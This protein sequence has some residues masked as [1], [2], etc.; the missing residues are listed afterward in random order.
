MYL[1]F[2]C[3]TMTNLSDLILEQDDED[4]KNL[5]ISIQSDSLAE[6][7]QSRMN[8]IYMDFYFYSLDL[9]IR[10][11]SITS[12]RIRR[13]SKTSFFNDRNNEY[14]FDDEHFVELLKRLKQQSFV[15]T[16]EDESHLF[17]ALLRKLRSFSIGI[18]RSF[19]LFRIVSIV[20]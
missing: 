14:I 1:V 4:V 20:C 10:T 8:L 17:D 15:L 19:V 12:K 7:Q 16:S 13:F 6:Q 11:N 2:Q 18:N 5:L 9:A 3:D